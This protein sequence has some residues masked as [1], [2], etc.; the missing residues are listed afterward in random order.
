MITLGILTLK[1]FLSIGAVTQTVDFNNQDLT[2]ILGENLDLGGDGAKNGT[3]KTSIL[4]G[5]SYS[6]FGG[7][8]NNIKKDNLINRTNGKAMVVTLSF[9]VDDIEYRIERGRKPT[10]LKF[11]VNDQEMASEETNDSQGDSRETQDAIEKVLHMSSDMF[12]HIVGLNTYNEPFLSLKANDQRVIIEQLLGVTILSEKADA[13][14]ILNKQTKDDIQQEEYRIRALE[15][16]NKRIG[17]QIENLKRRQRLWQTKH[18]EDLNKLVNEYDDLSKIDI[19]V[20]L[21][22]HK[23][24]SIYLSCLEKKNNYDN[25]VAKQSVWKKTRFEEIKALGERLQVLNA[26]DIESELQ[27]HKDLAVYKQEVIKQNAL[28]KELKR[29]NSDLEKENKISEKLANEIETLKE[30]KCYA[31]NQDFHDDNHKSVLSAKW[32]AFKAS[33]DREDQLAVERNATEKLTWVDIETS[34][35]THYKTESEAIKH[36]YTVI[37]LKIEIENLRQAEDPYILQIIDISADEIVC[38]DE[39]VTHYKTESEA[40]KHSSRVESLLDQIA[41]KHDE[42]DPYI[43]QISEMEREAIQT[44]S[45]DH[46]NE[47]TRLMQHQEYLL[48]LL[49][50]KKSFVRKKIIEQ[51]LTYLNSRLS[52]YLD[53]MGLPHTVVFQNDLTVEITE[54][55]RELDFDNLSR[56][57]RNRLI[58]GL[59]FSFRDVYESLYSP[60]NV[61]FVDELIDNGLD[62]IGVENSI[63]LLKDMA[64]R[65]NKSV[66]LVSHRDELTNRVSSVLKVIKEGGFTSYETTTETTV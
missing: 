50:N 18:D 57:E 9:S 26:I 24:R 20:E 38:G 49:T 48:D 65:R 63:A 45:F 51:N 60:I 31:C 1:N 22:S 21:Q 3:G 33:C 39:P 46:I 11:Y 12:R 56:G 27:A 37:N 64:R 40:I 58:L 8:I 32:S 44:V 61:L 2:L 62:T 15:E 34:P 29:I 42:T 14:K 17:E 23:D 55:G 19:T 59:S 41:N 6:L 13:I 25:L 52:F 5:L 53:S 4:Q 10:F 16:A 35:V 54:L 7:G 47:L 66:W 28:D 36:S 30:N 43:D